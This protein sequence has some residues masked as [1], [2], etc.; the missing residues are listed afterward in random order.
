MAVCP[1]CG[2][3]LRFDISSQGMK[4]DS[5][6]SM[7]DP[8]AF[9]YG[10]S[11]EESTEYDV[12][13]FK[14]PQCG[15]EIYS[16]DQTAAGFCSYCGS[17]SV[18]EGHLTKEKRPELIIPFKKTKE[19][20]KNIFRKFTKRAIF[21][22]SEF[23]SEGNVDSFR[24]I[25]MPY[26]LYDIS[27]GGHIDVPT[28]TSHRRGDYIIHD[29][30]MCSGELDSA[31][32][33][34]SYDASSSFA[35]DISN[36]I[37]PFNVKDIT[38]FSPSFLSGFYADV[39]DVPASVYEETAVELARESSYNYLKKK[40]PMSKESF[41][42]GKDEVKSMIGT[43][44]DCERSAMFP[45][46]FLTYRHG[47]RVAYAT[48]NG[49]SGK[50]SSDLPISIPKYL[51]CAGIVAA[52]A[53]PLLQ[54]LLTI[55]PS[56]LLG[57]IGVI[58]VIGALLYNHEMKKIAI[59]D[60]HDDDLG[61]QSRM[62]QKRQSRMD[63]QRGATFG[64]ES[65]AYV[66]TERDIRNSKRR[67]AA[68]KKT[69]KK[70]SNALMILILCFIFIPTVFH[71]FGGMIMSMVDTGRGLSMAV[72]IV[73]IISLVI[74]CILTYTSTN[75]IR[76]VESKRG[77]SSLLWTDIG[78]VI[79]MIILFVKPVGDIYYYIA[80]LATMAGLLIA[81]I[82][83]MLS[84]NILATRPLPQFELYKGGDDRA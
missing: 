12:T 50:V 64:N 2:G 79:S 27:Q 61:L 80:A 33:G 16:T 21:A 6:T 68:Q 44:I 65:E 13:V 52:I 42:K 60:N 9:Q 15:G 47:N 66:L 31:Y 14:C 35:D 73:L 69:E 62:E 70:G 22:P 78:M 4:C 34:V 24:G 37:A 45:V 57:I 51:L 72:K 36:E 38:A 56:T 7:F 75:H 11:A 43:Q 82:D 19:D 76:D 30:Y 26:W 1:N 81:L 46:W 32:N 83:L 39:A 5:C 77:V 28:S 53:F 71:I 54:M 25:Y 18:L 67:K 40:S 59:K 20:C 48:V 41:E 8:Y 49:Q 74:T 17:S 29:H 58:C 84:Y 3:M 55:L 10:N 23:R 63:A